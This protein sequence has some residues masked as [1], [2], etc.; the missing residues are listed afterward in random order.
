M[1][2]QVFFLCMSILFG[3][4]TM[5]FFLDVR[6][7]ELERNKQIVFF[8]GNLLI[9]FVNAVLIIILGTEQ[10]MKL[11]TL[12]IHLPHFLI[13]WATTQI[14]PIKVLFTQ[15]TAVFLIFPANIVLYLVQLNMI[16]LGQL[17]PHIAGLAV[18]TLILY[19]IHRFL[20]ADF[21]YLI[22]NYSSLDFFKLCLL[23]LTYNL[24]NYWLRMYN[25]STSM[26]SERFS[27]RFFLFII[28]LAAYLLILDIAKT[29][30]EKDS[31]Q[32]A[33]MALSLQLESANQQL[34]VLQTTQEQALIYRHDM[35]HHF[36]LIGGYLEEDHP[37]KALEYIRQAQADIELI[38]PNRYVDNNTVNLILC[39]FAA[40]AKPL[41]VALA[42][43]ADLPETLAVSETELCTL[44]SNGLENA[45]KAASKVEDEEFRTV[46][47]SCHVHKGNLLL[48][49]ENSF[50]GE[51]TMKNGL[52][53]TKLKG[54]GFGV[55]S[56]ALIAEKHKGYCAFTAED[57]LFT[58]K[59][60]LPL[61]FA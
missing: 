25:Y 37:G 5:M 1:A 33:Q 44:L 39:S 18:Y 55:K 12:L 58:L 50:T 3:I 15:F 7:K 21:N 61:G 8:L 23:P 29:A 45:I 16:E 56:M 24:I 30:R 13:F 60:V 17:T 57:Q 6:L 46:R 53:E 31:L 2:F 48:F 22:K 14:T 40:K 43:T 26:S 19:V 51:V 9:F 32:S 36:S 34:S 38:T 4:I 47:F 27:M 20:K 49:I 42:V 11:Y 59:I 35:R 28:T 41:G 10:H 52:P 54:H